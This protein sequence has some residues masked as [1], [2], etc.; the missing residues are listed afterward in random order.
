M[1]L[2]LLILLTCLLITRTEAGSA[3]WKSSSVSGDWNTA[4][5]WTPSTVPN[6][7][8]D[9]ATF[10]TSNTTAVSLSAA[11]AVDSVVFSPGA[12]AF[13]ITSGGSSPSGF[14]SLTGAGV[15]NNSGVTQRFLASGSTSDGPFGV[16][17]LGGNASGGSNTIFTATG[18]AIS[19]GPSALTEFFDNASGGDATFITEGGTI[20]NG[21]GAQ[22]LLFGTSTG[23]NATFI[24]N[25]GTASGAIGGTVGLRD[26]ASLGSGVYIANPGTNGGKGGLIEI[27]GKAR[28]GAARVQ[29]F[30]DGGI[31]DANGQFSIAAHDERVA[32]ISIGSLEGSGEVIIGAAGNGADSNLIV[33]SNN[34]STVFNGVIHGV[35]SGGVVTK[36]GT[37]TLSLGGAN[38]YAGG[39]IVS[40][41]TLAV[42]N[43][44]GSAT[45]PG[46]VQV[47]GGIIGGSGIIAGDVTLGTGSGSGAILDPG[48]NSRRPSQTTIQGAL[49][50]KADG[51]YVY[52]L[53]TKRAVESNVAVNGVTLENGAQIGIATVGN[54]KLTAGTVFTAI[55]N[56][57]ATPINGT[58]S[59]LSDG[60]TFTV[61]KNAFL[62][63]YSGG[64]GNDLTLT[65]MP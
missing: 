17:I 61:G 33:G 23:G 64:D 29:V 22:C 62:V 44:Q 39:T 65:V 63:S 14:L 47:A 53:N 1:K 30:G 40:S 5:N 37:G 54:V 46:P 42:T 3:T 21:S 4:A 56:T 24:A 58:F 31:N 6:G 49:T 34:L 2:A 35:G 60:S 51:D 20:A 45:G 15:T 27:L 41:G 52:R 50:I 10:A 12:N 13:T 32:D 59:N 48:V 8:S 26:K 11:V 55:S 38:A 43:Q 16:V 25:G 9:I 19:G 36:I 28:S 57:A 7:T 18:T